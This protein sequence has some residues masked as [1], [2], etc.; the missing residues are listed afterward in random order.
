VPN[1][2]QILSWGANPAMFNP[3]IFNT[4]AV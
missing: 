2:Q 4:F 3:L 1:V